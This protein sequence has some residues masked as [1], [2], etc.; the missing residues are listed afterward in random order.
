MIKNAQLFGSQEVKQQNSPQNNSAVCFS[1]R[2]Q[3]PG[4]MTSIRDAGKEQA[5][6]NIKG[7]GNKKSKATG[8]LVLG[9]KRNSP[10]VEA[11]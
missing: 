8:Q 6:P 1:E 4:C 7:N 10:F 3:L 5:T 11:G 9:L 2:A